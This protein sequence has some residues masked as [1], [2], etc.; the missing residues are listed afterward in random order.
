MI[1]LKYIATWF[2]IVLVSIT[3]GQIDLDNYGHSIRFDSG[4]SYELMEPAPGEKDAYQN[5][6]VCTNNEVEMLFRKGEVILD[7]FVNEY[8]AREALGQDDFYATVFNLMEKYVDSNRQLDNIYIAFENYDDIDMVNFEAGFAKH[9]KYETSDE[10]LLIKDVAKSNML[11]GFMIS[12]ALEVPEAYNPKE[13]PFYI[14]TLDSTDIYWSL[15]YFD[16]ITGNYVYSVSKQI[17][18]ENGVFHGVIAMD[19]SSIYLNEDLGS[20]SK[21]KQCQIILATHDGRI[22]YDSEGDDSTTLEAIGFEIFPE[23]GYYQMNNSGVKQEIY[24]SNNTFR[25]LHVYLKFKD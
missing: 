8:L 22:I 9:Y 12:P 14:N 5:L 25:N 24:Y 23:E 10:G 17:I 20:V 18:D 7:Y 2:I 13:R 15:P 6:V 16:A 3:G 11:H 4:S 1:F 19:I 21:D